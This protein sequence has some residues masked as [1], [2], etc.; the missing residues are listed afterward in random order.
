MKNKILINFCGDSFCSYTG[1]L[2]WCNLVA[3]FL[4]AEIIGSG[5][6]G[7]AHE[8][9]I[10]TFNEKTDITIFCW[11][12]PNRLYHKKY[13]FNFGSVQR[14]LSQEKANS[15]KEFLAANEYYQYLHNSNYAKERQIRDL[16]WFDHCVLEKS[17]KR[18]LHLFCYDNIY[19]FKNGINT[20]LIL[21][22][23]FKTYLRESKTK[24]TIYNHLTI[25]DNKKLAK[26]VLHF[27][28]NSC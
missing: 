24:Q 17:K 25:E 5:R 14:H 26:L 22:K 7:A 19:T 8:H 27:L 16:Y 12:E 20:S 2:S 23:N 11:T 15:K 10:K 18:F 3:S 13:S 28:K 9:A 6:D 4:N 1:E 21:K